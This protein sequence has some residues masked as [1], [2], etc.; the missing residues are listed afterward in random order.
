[1]KRFFDWIRFNRL[2]IKEVSSLSEEHRLAY[3][4]F[5]LD[6]A[7]HEYKRFLKVA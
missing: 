2:S 6:D 4:L 1:M 7:I 3:I 5:R